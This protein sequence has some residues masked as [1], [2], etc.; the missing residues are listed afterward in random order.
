MED[1]AA[2]AEALRLAAESTGD[3]AQAEAAIALL[4]AVP[5]PA[6][7]SVALPLSAALRTLGALTDDL[8]ALDAAVVLARE[9]SSGPAARAALGAALAVLGERTGDAEALGAALEAYE[10]AAF[11][12]PLFQTRMRRNQGAVLTLLGGVMGERGLLIEA[13][14]ALREA[15]A[16]FTALNAAEDAALA[17]ENLCHTLRLLGEPGDDKALLAEAV[18]AGR[19]AL[20]H[21]PPGRRR[22][23]AETNLANAL[24]ALGPAHH[25]EALALYRAALARLTGP[26]DGQ[27]RAAARH[28]LL[29][30]ERIGQQSPP[31]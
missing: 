12:D 7:A 5:P 8:D 24:L 11:P 17:A 9:A 4:R 28:N 2:A 31:V 25:A 20:E 13:A 19:A 22:A 3:P 1:P 15:R 29:R 16:R 21:V 23:S 10:T 18:S 30:A 27:R 6:R 26:A 14:G